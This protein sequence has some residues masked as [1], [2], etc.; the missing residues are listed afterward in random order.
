MSMR[1]CSHLD[2]VGA[3]WNPLVYMIEIIGLP[4]TLQEKNGTYFVETALGG[5]RRWVIMSQARTMDARRL[6]ERVG[7]LDARTFNKIR[8]QFCKLIS[9]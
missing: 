7:T 6:L 3:P 4:L 2:K 8:D 9:S 1:D 5:V